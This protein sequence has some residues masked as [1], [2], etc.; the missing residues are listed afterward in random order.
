MKEGYCCHNCPICGRP[1]GEGPVEAKVYH[2]ACLMRVTR[3][4]REE[5]DGG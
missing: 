2:M 1:V 3:H 5:V 4:L